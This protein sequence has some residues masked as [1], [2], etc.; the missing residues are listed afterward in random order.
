MKIE[1]S[2]KNEGQKLRFSK[3][4]RIIYPVAL[5]V[6]IVVFIVCIQILARGVEF[7]LWQQEELAVLALGVGIAVVLLL[8]YSYKYYRLLDKTDKFGK[9]DSVELWLLLGWIPNVVLASLAFFNSSFLIASAAI[10]VILGQIISVL[11]FLFVRK[12]WRPY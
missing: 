6:N 3:S 9:A 12:V 2:A 4:F 7:E 10:G 1:E 8:A 5:G 11:I